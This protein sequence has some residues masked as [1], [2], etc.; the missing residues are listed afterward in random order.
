ME[1]SQLI[2]WNLRNIFREK[3]YPKRRAETS[4]RPFPANL[5]LNISLNQ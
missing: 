4:L 1:F 5:K 3:S 2:E